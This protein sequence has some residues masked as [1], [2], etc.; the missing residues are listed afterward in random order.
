MASLLSFLAKRFV[1]GERMEDAIGAARR[2]NARGIGAILDFLGEDVETRED[3]AAAADEYI[4]LLER[5]QSEKVDA[6]VSLKVS[7]MGLRVSLDVCYE[8]LARVIA[9]AA[10]HNQFVWFDMEGSA[11]TQKTIEVFEKLRLAYPYLGLCLQAYLVR[12]GGDLDRLTRIPFSVRLC[13]GAYKEPPEIAYATKRAVDGNFRMLT[14][15]LV[16]QAA[17]DGRQN[18]PDRA[19]GAAGVYPAFATHDRFLVD[20][21]VAVAAEKK[22]D[23]KRFEFQ[24]LYGIENR[25]LERLACQGFRTRVY[26]PYG[27]AWLPYFVRR[28]RERKE[29]VFFL[30]RNLFRR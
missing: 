17:R 6:Q 28:L 4:R 12:T 14:Q 7:Q 24:M 9:T 15:K 10:R 20:Y 3:A 1:A 16:E 22:L 29:N 13:K 2:M 21:I 23:A 19:G 25:L 30:V 5:I 8:N 18:P 11:L 27:T 26:I